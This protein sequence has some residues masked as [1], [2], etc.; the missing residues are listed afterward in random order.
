MLTQQIANE[1]DVNI[2]KL[3]RESLELYLRQKLREIDVQLFAFA[4]KYGVSN[5]L[6]FDELVKRGKVHEESSF[7]DF[8]EFDNLEADRDKIIEL[9]KEW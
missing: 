6:E 9:L 7:E 8:F 3:E 4:K 2:N 5:I 1:L